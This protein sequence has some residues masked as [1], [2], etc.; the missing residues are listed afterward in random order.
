VADA[1]APQADGTFVGHCSSFGLTPPYSDPSVS[2]QI[3]LSQ[4]KAGLVEGSFSMHARDSLGITGLPMGS[5]VIY[6]GAFSVGCRD[7]RP[8]SDPA[9][10]MRSILP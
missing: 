7:G 2:G 1:S 3:V 5:D 10:A 6:T 8:I 4:S 9:C